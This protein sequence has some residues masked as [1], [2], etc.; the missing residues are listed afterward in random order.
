MSYAAFSPAIEFVDTVPAVAGATVTMRQDGSNGTVYLQSAAALATLTVN[1]PS[2]AVSRAGQVRRLAS[3]QSVVA[4]TMTGGTVLNGVPSLMPADLLEFRCIGAGSWICV[5]I[6]YRADWDAT[7]GLGVILNKPPIQPR[8]FQLL[9]AA[10]NTQYFFSATQDAHVS[11]SVQMEVGPDDHGYATLRHEDQ[12]AADFQNICTKEVRLSG[13][14]GI[15][16]TMSSVL[17][18]IIPAGRYARIATLVFQGTPIFAQLVGQV[19]L[20]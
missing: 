5:P 14:T 9:F 4:L 19:V 3:D 1:L 7:E 18:G 16:L 13:P 2:V 20:L 12:T 17:T 10:M 11:F 6:Q 15:A 8:E